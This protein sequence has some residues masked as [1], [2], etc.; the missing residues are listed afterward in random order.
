[1]YRFK[2]RSLVSA[3]AMGMLLLPGTV[4]RGGLRVQGQTLVDQTTGQPLRGFYAGYAPPADFKT[5]AADMD[6]MKHQFGLKGFTFEIGWNTIEPQRGRFVFDPRYDRILDL[7]RQKDLKVT[8]FF[9]P[10]Y[11]PQWVYEQNDAQGNPLDV[12]NR[13][14]KGKIA[15]GTWLNYSPS[16]PAALQWQEEFQ[17]RAIEHYK[18]QPAVIGFNLTN[19]LTY[20]SSA[21]LD[22]ST[23]ADAA[24]KKW[25]SRLGLPPVSMPRPDEAAARPQ[26]WRLWQ[27]FRQDALNHYFNTTYEQARAVLGKGDTQLVYHRHNFYTASDA[28]VRQNANYLD[29]NLSEGDSTGGNVYGVNGIMEAMMQAWN[30]P[31]FLTETSNVRLADGTHPPSPGEMNRMLLTQF[32]RGAQNQTVFAFM[33]GNFYP[34]RTADGGVHPSFAQFKAMAR[35]VGQIKQIDLTPPRRVGYLWPRNYVAVRGDEYWNVQQLYSEMIEQGRRYAQSPLIVFPS[36]LQP[37][38]PNAAALKNLKLIYA[39]RHGG[40]DQAAINAPALRQ[41]VESGGVLVVELDAQSAPPDWSGVKAAPTTA[42]RFKMANGSPLDAQGTVAKGDGAWALSGLDKVWASW[43]G[44]HRPAVGLKRVQNGKVILVGTAAFPRNFHPYATL[45]T[46]AFGAEGLNTH[47]QYYRAGNNVLVLPLRKEGGT[48]FLPADWLGN[49][50]PRSCLMNLT[51]GVFTDTRPH[52]DSNNRMAFDLP[53]GTL[54]LL[55][56]TVPLDSLPRYSGGG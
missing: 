51:S 56:A 2:L 14:E 43:E 25:R 27:I 50:K 28:Y 19:E 15:N 42:A 55:T 32:F 8:L 26:D 39:L 22:Y 29:P 9:T 7:A 24:W 35:K 5:V 40:L 47:F 12:H 44:T 48:V 6:A 53:P 45:D 17:R 10:H 31:I 23:W 34:M 37:H 36:S 11:T 52:A 20:G 3:L 38:A 46:L 13:D 54:L 30:K 16:S 41:W 18:S 21:W 1:M 49:A 4:S 33:S